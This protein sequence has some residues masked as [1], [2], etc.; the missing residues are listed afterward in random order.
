MRTYKHRRSHR[1][2]RL[3]LEALED[4]SLLTS[5]TITDLGTGL[6]PTA[7]NNNGQ[8]VGYMENTSTQTTT[9]FLW[10]NGTLTPLTGVGANPIATG[11][12]D[13]EEVVGTNI[14]KF[15]GFL[16]NVNTGAVTSLPLD[17]VA[18]N[19]AGQVAGTGDGAEVY[20]NGTLIV[21]N[22]PLSGGAAAFA[23]GISGNGLV[24]G[25]NSGEPF[26]WNPATGQVTNL[27]G[28]GA[29]AF[30]VNNSGQ[31]TGFDGLNG[32]DIQ[33]FLY[34]DGV[35]QDLGT[36]AGP[37]VGDQSYGNAINNAGVVVGQDTA[38][39]AFVY[40]NG[41]MTNLNSLVPAG[42]GFTLNNAVAIN[43]S[44]QILVQATNAAG[45]EEAVLLNPVATPSLTVTSAPSLATAG[46]PFNITVT[47]LN[48]NGTVDTGFTDTVQLVGNASGPISYTFTT[49]DQG[50]HT[51]TATLDT[52]GT[53]TLTFSDST[54]PGVTGV[55]Q[56]IPVQGGPAAKLLLSSPTFVGAGAT[57]SIEVTALDAFNNIATDYL[58][59]VHFTDSA[60]GATLPANF[61]FTTADDSQHVFTGVKLTK[62]GEQTIT[63]TDTKTASI[64]GS[65][66]IDVNAVRSAALAT[67]SPLAI[68]IIG[69]DG[70]S[71]SWWSP[72]PTRKGSLAPGLD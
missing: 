1:S 33:A 16:L 49:A 48:P 69:S 23:T 55:Q 4:R 12:N 22:N 41:V 31:A 50:V 25:F 13:S 44:G 11:I 38:V 57:F 46:V 72:A 60:S 51:F 19:D 27:G 24:S 8:A 21:S 54:N 62:A 36:L 63:V 61:T 40:S 32:A 26:I 14:G 35:L 3:R 34:S 18:I 45:T 2:L 68:G 42:S 58:G 5:Y 37:S 66:P 56:N 9:S 53:Q 64:K 59:T 28:N 7:L 30:G 29:E 67:T 15:G 39:G 20:Q 52:A 10:S 70:D 65:I 6:I 43:N 47:V 17:P 71:D